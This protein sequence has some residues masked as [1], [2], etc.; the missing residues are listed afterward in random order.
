M[1]LRIWGSV[2]A[3]LLLVGC[4]RERVWVTSNLVP[5]VH[6]ISDSADVQHLV[7][8]QEEN[9]A[10]ELRWLQGL[11]PRGEREPNAEQSDAPVLEHFLDAMAAEPGFSVRGGT[12]CRLLETS[13]AR[14]SR[15]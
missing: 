10:A 7:R 8:L 14:C 13:Q 6:I 3:I 1:C 4:N 15:Y 9:D 5:D 2:T 12:W 11:E